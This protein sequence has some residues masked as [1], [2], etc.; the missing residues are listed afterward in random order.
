MATLLHLQKRIPTECERGLMGPLLQVFFYFRIRLAI[1]MIIISMS[2]TAY[3][4]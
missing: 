2:S 1:I 3:A 4:G